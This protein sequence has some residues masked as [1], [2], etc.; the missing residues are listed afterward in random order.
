MERD[1]RAT[2]LP[3]MTPLPQMLR[4]TLITMRRTCG[5]STCRCQRGQL[6]EGPA[7]SVSVSGTSILISLRPADVPAVEAALE[8]YRLSRDSLE[9]QARAG[10][11]ALRA[12]NARR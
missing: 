5:K 4:G 2:P 10:V 8:R 7:V 6:H 9:E 11:A 1:E 3:E 12:R